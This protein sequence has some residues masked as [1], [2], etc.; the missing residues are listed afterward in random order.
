MEANTVDNTRTSDEDTRTDRN[1]DN[2]HICV[3]IPAYNEAETVDRVVEECKDVLTA[4]GYPHDI[5]V[6]DDGSTDNTARVARDAGATV[7][8]HHTNKGLGNTY[9]TG[10]RHA[11][12]TDADILVNIDADGQY[13]TE[14]MLDL[15][16]TVKNR[17][18]D[19]ALGVRD[20]FSL[21]HMPRGKKIGNTIGSLVTS[22]LSGFR[23][24]D[25]QSGFRAMTREC[26]LHMNLNGD[27]TYVQE[28]LIQASHKGFRIRQVPIMFYAR[29][30]GESRLI[31]SLTEYIKHAAGIVIRTYRDYKPLQTFFIV[32][33]LF[34]LAATVP[35]YQ[36]LSDFLATGQFNMFGR[37]LLVMLLTIASALTMV[38]GL[39]A[40]MLKTQRQLQEQLLYEFK[41]RQ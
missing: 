16:D 13:R 5:L 25:A 33:M 22:M 9:N 15:I 31:G 8:S 23:V 4:A 20:V 36:V 11:L 40:D 14:D 6:I 26:A 34:L 12:E 38:V 35:G 19:M 21:D 28:S 17:E 7:F 37:G 39:L 30:S 3:T 24:K 2:P 27:Y 41:K 18:A 1:V 32:A 29:E 10:L